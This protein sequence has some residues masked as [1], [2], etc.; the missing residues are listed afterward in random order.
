MAKHKDGIYPMAQITLEELKTKISDV[1][2]TECDS[3]GKYAP[4]C[5]NCSITHVDLGYYAFMALVNEALEESY[6]MGIN[7]QR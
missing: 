5:N 6:R 1:L 2:F 4:K 3:C 7:I